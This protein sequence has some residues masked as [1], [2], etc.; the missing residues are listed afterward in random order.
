MWTKY[1]EGSLTQRLHESII[2]L[3]LD[4]MPKDMPLEVDAI[5]C[6]SAGNNNNIV[7]KVH[8]MLN[9]GADCVSVSESESVEETAIQ[10]FPH[11]VLSLRV[12]R[13]KMF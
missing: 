6:I 5:V 7:V 2:R 10:V 3:C 11:D 8:E 12:S 4:H 13:S 1:Y 9:D